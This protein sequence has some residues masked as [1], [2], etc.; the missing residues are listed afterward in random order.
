MDR[1]AQNAAPQPPPPNRN[2]INTAVP[3]RNVMSP[4]AAAARLP[5]AKG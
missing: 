4:I 1:P 5:G 3:I 2:T